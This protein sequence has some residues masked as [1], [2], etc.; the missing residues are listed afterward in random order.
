MAEETLRYLQEEGARQI[1]VVNR[2]F[3]RAEELARRW[4]GRALAVGR[5]AAGA[6]GRRPGHQHHGRRAADRHGGAVRRGRGRGGPSG[7]C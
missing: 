7:R 5:I 4:H 2:H 6:G 1:T 3:D